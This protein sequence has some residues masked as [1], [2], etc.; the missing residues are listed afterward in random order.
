MAC[1]AGKVTVKGY[2]RTKP[3]RFRKG[4]MAASAAPYA[5]VGNGRTISTHRTYSA[6]I[7]ARKR[8]NLQS[9]RA[10]R[11]RPYD[12]RKRAA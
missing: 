8:A 7:N 2:W 9:F 5:V 12:V 10:G 11:G 3:R 4:P 6:A 1:S